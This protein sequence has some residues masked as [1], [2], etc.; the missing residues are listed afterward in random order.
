[1]CAFKI[2]AHDV[3]SIDFDGN[4]FFIETWKSII[5]QIDRLYIKIDIINIIDI[6]IDI[7]I[8]GIDIDI[9]IDIKIDIDM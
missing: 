7:D 5:S 6:D 4:N 8:H 2:W 3:I 1:M 9:D